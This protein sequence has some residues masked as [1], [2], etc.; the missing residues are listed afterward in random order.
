MRKNYEN[1]KKKLAL[2]WPSGGYVP[3]LPL[4]RERNA[5]LVRE[6]TFLIWPKENKRIWLGREIVKKKKRRRREKQKGSE[7][8]KSTEADGGKTGVLCHSERQN[9]T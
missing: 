4:R 2:S 6:L 7:K 1:V 5:S 9:D 8:E 3:V